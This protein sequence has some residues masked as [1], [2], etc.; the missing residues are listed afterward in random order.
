[1]D[2]WA[3]PFTLPLPLILT[4]TLALTLTLTLNTVPLPYQSKFVLVGSS[5]ITLAAMTNFMDRW[6][7]NPAPIPNALSCCLLS[8]CPF[9]SLFVVFSLSLW[10]LHMPCPCLCFSFLVLLSLR[11]FFCL[12]LPSL[13]LFGFSPRTSVVLSKVKARLPCFNRLFLHINMKDSAS[14]V[15]LCLV[16][17]CLVLSCSCL[18]LYAF[19]RRSL[20]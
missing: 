8:L 13:W 4:L 6:S 10:I 14:K 12:C 17:S 9:L 16:L 3:L 15:V 20:H 1:M 5:Q 19:F 7:F 11:P 2:V 18:A